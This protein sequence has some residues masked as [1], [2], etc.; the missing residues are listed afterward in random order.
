MSRFIDASA[1]RFSERV[2]YQDHNETISYGALSDRTSQLANLL[3]SNGLEKGDRVGILLRRNLLSP[4][5]VHAVLKSGG[6]F[7]PIDPSSPPQ[8]IATIARDCQ[9]RFLVTENSS[10][11][12][13][14]AALKILQTTSSDTDFDV[15]GLKNKFET[16]SVKNFA[17]EELAEFS[18]SFPPANLS[19]SDL[20]YVMYTS[21]STGPPKGIR[22]THSSGYHYALFS[23]TT[24]G[25]RSDDCIGSHSPLHFDMSTLGYLT[26]PLV[27]AATTIVPAA[28][29]K[30]P[31]NLSDLIE[32]TKITI[33][34]SVPFAL[35]QLLNRGILDQRDLSRLR[36]ILYGGEP[37]PTRQLQRL[38][39]CIPHAAISNVYGPAEVNQCTYFHIP[40]FKDD[41]DL[42][43]DNAA[44]PI[45]QT[46]DQTEALIEAINSES[47]VDEPEEGELCIH[48]PTMM[49][50]YWNRPDLNRDCF[51]E[52]VR[53]N[54]TKAKFYRTGD[55]VRKDKFGVLHLVGRV[56][57]QVKI[58]GHRI[59]LDQIENV[60]TSHTNIE[61][62]AVFAIDNPPD[63]KQ[64]VAVVL[65]GETT[66]NMSSSEV[67]EF[68]KEH[69]PKYCI[70]EVVIIESELPRTST[71]KI[72]RLKIQDNSDLTNSTIFK[73][74][75]V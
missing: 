47:A 62:A 4:I 9:I 60:L 26:A 65:V 73:K 2:A 43:N 27:G 14:K 25:I 61:E 52:L 18:K 28:F 59:E 3:K 74:A 31:V 17:W 39:K 7:V 24:Y 67:T 15:V 53:N 32:S 66:G 6:V 11:E 13:V 22:H 23:A 8:R 55:L 41:P 58:R 49:E 30:F 42:L 1:Q 70:P 68:A 46:W 12:S 33:W 44:V 51:L 40:P 29:T 56:D 48:S 16:T 10:A 38:R 64:L 63:S 19:G 69:L 54:G 72:D 71:G 50:G 45:G 57:R 20:A 75:S 21:G 37:F 5:A 34:Y 35:I 36:W